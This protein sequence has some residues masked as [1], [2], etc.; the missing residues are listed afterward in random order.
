MDEDAMS[1]AALMD[2]D[3]MDEDMTDEHPMN[4]AELMNS[5]FTWHKAKVWGEV[6]VEN[7]PYLN[8][9]DPCKWMIAVCAYDRDISPFEAPTRSLSLEDLSVSS[10]KVCRTIS[11]AATA[12]TSHTRQTATRVMV[13]WPD[14]QPMRVA[15]VGDEGDD[16]EEDQNEDVDKVK[17]DG[18]DDQHRETKS[19]YDVYR[20]ED[21]DDSD[22]PDLT[23]F[24]FYLPDYPADANSD[25][26]VEWIEEK[27]Q[28][29]YTEHA[30]SCPR[31][32]RVQL[33]TRVLDLGTRP[34][35]GI[36]EPFLNSSVRSHQTPAEGQASEYIALSH[37]WGLVQPIRTTHEKYKDYAKTDGLPLSLLPKTFQ[38]AVN[39]CR[40][41][42]FRYLWIDSLC[43][44][45][46]DNLDWAREA[47]RMC[48]VYQN[49]TFVISATLAPDATAGLFTGDPSFR[50]WGPCGDV[51]G[52][53]SI[54]GTGSMPHGK[55]ESVVPIYIRRHRDHAG[56][57]IGTGIYVPPPL[58][59]R[60]WAYQERML[61]R[62]VLHFFDNEVIWECQDDLDCQCG[63]V[64][65]EWS[66]ERFSYAEAVKPEIWGKWVE[67]Y[68]RLAL[69]EPSDRL[70]AL[71]GLAKFFSRQ[72]RDVLGEYLAGIWTG[73]FPHTLYWFVSSGTKLRPRPA[74][75]RAPSWSWASV[76][77]NVVVT[78]ELK[79][80]PETSL[81]NVLEA[82]CTPK[83]LDSFGE[84][85]A[86]H[87]R[88]SAPMVAAELRINT[89][90]RLP[91]Q[92][93]YQ[94]FFVVLPSTRIRVDMDYAWERGPEWINIGQPLPEEGGEYDPD[95][96]VE[97]K[98]RHQRTFYLI[99]L[100]I[101]D[102]GL[103]HF[104]L[105][106]KLQNSGGEEGS[107]RY[108]RIGY[109]GG[110]VCEH[111]FDGFEDAE[112]TLL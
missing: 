33:P 110:N 75:Y 39:V 46:D 82:A 91:E 55:E 15:L 13:K 81:I 18:D 50:W 51:S 8:W 80:G 89:G 62:R 49:A 34:E 17:D 58:S 61:A 101:G 105:L 25:A 24:I 9:C 52:C 26:T 106:K 109:A 57:E 27:L 95:Q 85:I 96:W 19:Y 31:P 28:E 108:E 74:S 44:I 23:H 79:L 43:I 14:N 16:K 78:T 22:Q 112:I 97:F 65:G 60:G 63:Q 1:P 12:I 84:I 56:Y 29:C 66:H 53:C 7:T 107:Q 32:D 111:K 6:F 102:N 92:E 30:D 67:A 104:L 68:S 48:D 69:T 47:A 72:H 90:G 71:S 87:I 59:K 11:Q 37:C 45:Q 83:G 86:G 77:N 98:F 36:S 103:V 76:N 21:I 88:I 35:H 20:R 70:P 4:P 54:S 41:L 73:Q 5:M 93:S 100:S 99:K 64:V 38:D 42:G 10:C 2:E 40:R 3:M 94:E